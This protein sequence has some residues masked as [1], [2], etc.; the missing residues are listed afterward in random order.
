MHLP[1]RLSPVILVCLSL[2]S[3]PTMR[4]QAAPAAFTLQITDTSHPPDATLAPGEQ[5]F[6][7][8][9]YDSALP[10]QIWT[11]PYLQGKKVG[12]AFTNTSVPHAGLGETLG[13]FSVQSPGA[14]I[15]EIRLQVSGGKAF[16]P[17]REFSLPVS[18][19]IARTPAAGQPRPGWV[20]PLLAADAE[21]SRQALLHPAPLSGSDGIRMLGVGV[22][23][24]AGLALGIAGPAWAALRWRGLWRLAAAPPILYAGFIFVRILVDTAR[25]PTS[26]NLWPFEIAYA[27]FKTAAYMVVLLLIRFA[28]RR[29]SP[30]APP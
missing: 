8:I 2:L 12:D 4:A 24:L 26:H 10:V 29:L 30:A 20:A 13:W 18:L 22:L 11:H 16:G 7:R 9:T 25:D 27:S 1:A 28:Q 21:K 14:R 15:D 5:F 6:L 23:S 17:D 3:A 19:S